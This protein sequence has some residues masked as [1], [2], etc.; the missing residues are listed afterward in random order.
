M[1]LDSHAPE[2][3]ASGLACLTTVIPRG[4]AARVKETLTFAALA[5]FYIF[6]AQA[7]PLHARAGGEYWH[8]DSGWIFPEKIAGFERVGVPQDV[9]GSRTAAAYYARVE[10]GQRMVA[11]VEVTPINDGD[12]W[13]VR[14]GIDVVPSA[15]AAAAFAEFVKFQR[16]D[17]LGTR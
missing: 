5:L 12:T 2:P 11:S 13:S 14:F 7:D 9:A 17:T 15:T 1:D 6:P 3:S 8:H 16:W 10:N 4:Q